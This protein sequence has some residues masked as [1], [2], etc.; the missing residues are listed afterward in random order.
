MDDDLSDLIIQLKSLRLRETRILEQ[1][2]CTRAQEMRVIQQIEASRER[3]R[4][5][6]LV[7][8]EVRRQLPPPPIVQA[9][10]VV[11][12]PVAI[13]APPAAPVP[14]VTQEE[15]IQADP[16]IR[17]QRVHIHNKVRRRQGQPPVNKADRLA[18]VTDYD[19]LLDKVSIVTDNGFHTWRLSKNLWA[20]D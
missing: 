11:R 12:A 14:M 18:T 9:P 20:I 3:R 15:I 13:R 1:L 10:V 4:H 6:H 2:E 16:F 7:V 8:P 5:P 19:R 17:G